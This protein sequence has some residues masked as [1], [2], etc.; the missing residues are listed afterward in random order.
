M[1]GSL[2]SIALLAKEIDKVSTLSSRDN[3]IKVFDTL[4]GRA[5][6]T[7]VE[8]PSFGEDNGLAPLMSYL[9]YKHYYDVA[10]P[11]LGEAFNLKKWANQ[12]YEDDGVIPIGNRGHDVNSRWIVT[13][14]DG[15][16]VF[17]NSKDAEDFRKRGDQNPFR[18]PF[19]RHK[20]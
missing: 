2:E 8:I 10:K 4:M 19:N 11:V 20:L 7:I 17:L 15:C 12:F 1:V 3:F 13:G 9:V 16:F 14:D 18:N 5:D 6:S